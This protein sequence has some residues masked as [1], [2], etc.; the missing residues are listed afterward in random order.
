MGTNE[1]SPAQMTK[2]KQDAA[3]LLRIRQA[4]GP[5]DEV[6]PR[7]IQIVAEAAADSDPR[8][9]HALVIA[10]VQFGWMTADFLTR[11]ARGHEL[12]AS[13]LDVLLEMLQSDT[14]G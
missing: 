5:G 12:N 2:A 13:E 11:S 14:S 6:D 3:V 1:I 4:T 10:L 7:A 8:T 9:V